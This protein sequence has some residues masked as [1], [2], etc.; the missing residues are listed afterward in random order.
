MYHRPH[1]KQRNSRTRRQGR[2]QTMIIFVLVSTVVFMFLAIAADGGFG[3]YMSTEAQNAAD[4]ASLA[5]SSLLQQNC[6]YPSSV[7]ENTIYETVDALVKENMPQ[8]SILNPSTD[9]TAIFLDNNGNVLK[10]SSGDPYTVQDSSDNAP[11]GACG[12]KITVTPN[13][14]PFISGI[15]GVTPSSATAIS[16]A[17]Y[18]PSNQLSV[19]IVSLGT[20][21]AHNLF[22]GGSGT[23]N[24]IGTIASNADG[25][26]Y[27]SNYSTSSNSCTSGEINWGSSSG[28]A[29]DVIDTRAQDLPFQDVR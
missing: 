5:S 17:V 22:V 6:Y 12:I 19:S 3:L 16:K 4:F 21:E 2:G 28:S 11:D 29:I 27:C 18:N 8:S 20:H 25:I 26:V 14:L 7:K 1:V 13:W 23:F 9:W 24:V 10:D 15:A